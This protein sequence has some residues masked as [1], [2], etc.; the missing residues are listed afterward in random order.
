MI[1]RVLFLIFGVE[2]YELEII[3]V[4][5][6]VDFWWFSEWDQWVKYIRNTEYFQMSPVL[7]FMV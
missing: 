7:S 4:T 3:T 6:S 5:K 1:N 2:F